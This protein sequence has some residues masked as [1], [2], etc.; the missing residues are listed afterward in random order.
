MVLSILSIFHVPK[1]KSTFSVMGNVVDASSGRMNMETYS[2]VQD[3]KYALKSRV[4]N[5]DNKSVRMFH[6]NDRLFSP[7]DPTLS[8][9]M[10]NSY[11]T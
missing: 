5:E 1:V 10:R 2:A 3:I 8:N 7:V 4:P 6:R 9:S 11:K